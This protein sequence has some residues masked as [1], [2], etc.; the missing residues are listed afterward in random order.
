MTEHELT[1]EK[2]GELYGAVKHAFYDD[3]IV[4]SKS[5]YLALARAAYDLGKA[6]QGDDGFIPCEVEDIQKGDTVERTVTYEDGE[7][8][9]LT[10]VVSHVNV[11]DYWVDSEGVAIATDDPDSTYR[12]KPAKV[13]PPDPEKH[14]LILDEDGDAWV[15]RPTAEKYECVDI[16]TQATPDDFGN[17]WQPAKIIA[18]EDD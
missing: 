17:A 13:T 5:H 18:K 16:R 6:A 9:I 10:A 14:P 1:E 2:I 3:L 15:W 7:V 12:R 8:L 11:Y 4:H